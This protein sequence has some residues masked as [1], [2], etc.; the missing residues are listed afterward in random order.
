MKGL[1]I[2]RLFISNQLLFIKTFFFRILTV[3]LFLCIPILILNC[4]VSD[5]AD[6]IDLSSVAVSQ[7]VDEIFSGSVY[8][9]SG[10]SDLLKQMVNTIYGL[11]DS[12]LIN[13]PDYPIK[14]VTVYLVILA[15]YVFYRFF[16]GL[17][18]FS[19]TVGLKEFMTCGKP[20][21]YSWGIYK[22]FGKF[23]PYQFLYI[24]ISS[25]CDIFIIF[26]VIGAYVSF[27]VELEL[28]GVIITA[29]L[30]LICFAFRLSVF[31]FWSPAVICGNERVFR[32]LK[33]SLKSVIDRFLQVFVW[34]FITLTVM[35]AVMVIAEILIKNNIVAFAVS[36]CAL[37]L[38]G[39]ELRCMCLT[40]YFESQ[41][42]PYFTKKLD[43]VVKN[44]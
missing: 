29:I 9:V 19:M 35:L 31:S 32:S 1:S 33:S 20:A 12:L 13:F 14:A 44:D 23:I 36:V 22:N 28:I 42:K 43:L 24:L 15:F 34:T 30:A 38:C 5:F 40:Q 17:F 25:I 21:Q 37:L 27:F 11:F 18:D 39:Y 3:V 16:D 2:F 26:A 8:S 4:S 10:V 7:L 41:G 6:F